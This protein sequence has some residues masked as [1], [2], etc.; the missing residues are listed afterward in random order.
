MINSC[1]RFREK[2]EALSWLA[3]AVPE[4]ELTYRIFAEIV[5]GDQING[6]PVFAQ[7]IADQLSRVTELPLWF[8][9]EIVRIPVNPRSLFWEVDTE[10]DDILESELEI[11]IAPYYAATSLLNSVIDLNISSTFVCSSLDERSFKKTLAIY[12]EKLDQLQAGILKMAAS[13][14]SEA[15]MISSVRAR[16]VTINKN[17]RNIYA[18][19]Q[20]L[21][22]L[23]VSDSSIRHMIVIDG[24]YAYCLHADGV[25]KIL[26]KLGLSVPNIVE[27]GRGRL[28]YMLENIDFNKDTL[29]SHVF[30][31]PIIGY[32]AIGTTKPAEI[33]GIG[34]PADVSAKLDGDDDGDIIDL[35][36]SIVVKN[37]VMEFVTTTLN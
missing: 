2:A 19:A 24:D 22:D 29:I 15:Y 36:P 37:K 31:H 17:H 25:E 20:Q 4:F 14:I 11:E 27:C 9:N 16:H 6:I 7:S 33:Y 3:S 28:L 10:L 12:E 8:N 26:S 34:V 30:R 13:E 21:G 18:P 32:V 5:N 23:L 1:P 35:V